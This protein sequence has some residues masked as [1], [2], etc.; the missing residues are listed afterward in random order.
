MQHLH[1]WNVSYAEA[2]KLQEQLAHKVSFRPL[3]KRLK[4]IAGL[5]CA[6]A[7]GGKRII[8]AVIVL[9]TSETHWPEGDKKKQ[10]RR[11]PQ[12]EQVEMYG[13]CLGDFAI[14]HVLHQ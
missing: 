3:S 9:E 7:N 4:L 12:F 2:R 11:S 14:Q 13:S 6:F 10:T 8:A 5:D 1:D